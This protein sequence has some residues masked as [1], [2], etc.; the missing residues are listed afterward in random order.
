M[1]TPPSYDKLVVE[2]SKLI[3]EVSTLQRYVWAKKSHGLV[4]DSVKLPAPEF[5]IGT[6]DGKT[7]RTFL[8]ASNMYL[9]LT[10]I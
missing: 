7:L 3:S 9:K 2:L 5:F 1:S 8:N 6:H 4:P 10:C